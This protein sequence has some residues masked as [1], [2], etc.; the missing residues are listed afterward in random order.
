MLDSWKSFGPIDE[1]DDEAAA[2]IRLAPLTFFVG[3]PDSGKTNAIDALR[4]MHNAAS[5]KTL[6]EALDG[7]N[8]A[9][10]LWSGIDGGAKDAVF[11]EAD[12]FGISTT[13]HLGDDWLIHDLVATVTDD[14]GV[15][16]LVSEFLCNAR[17]KTRATL[18]DTHDDTLR[19]YADT[20]PDDVIRVSFRTTK[21]G[22]RGS[23]GYKDDKLVLT[24]LEPIKRML[25]AVSTST[26]KVRAAARDIVF[27][28]LDDST[29]LTALLFRIPEAARPAIAH[30]L[31]LFSAGELTGVAYDDERFAVIDQSGAKRTVEEVQLETLRFLGLVV[32]LHSAPPGG[33]VVVEHPEVD[34]ASPQITVLVALLETVVERRGVQIVA[35]TH[36]PELV[37][38]L[39]DEDLRNVVAFDRDDDGLTA[40]ISVRT[41]EEQGIFEGTPVL[42]GL[43]AE[44]WLGGSED[45]PE[46][47]P[48]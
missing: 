45:A 35:T 26:A 23:T 8:D 6:V 36:S 4:F 43:M 44:G 29:R 12:T 24:Q 11:E 10:A 27:A 28:D 15:A 2:G 39:S 37:S 20:D 9:D 16:L 19:R 7:P 42:D 46:A 31:P 47:E 41:L 14:D 25:P 38:Q 32:A 34:L 5:G 21:L 33:L 48:T 40:C 18:Y 17:T 30:W 22:E 3:P 1:D 13:W